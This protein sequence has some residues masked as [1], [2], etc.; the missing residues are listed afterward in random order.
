M[1]KRLEDWLKG[2]NRAIQGNG[3]DSPGGLRGDVL[4]LHAMLKE[5]LRRRRRRE[6]WIAAL[7][8][9]SFGSVLGAGVW[10][11]ARAYF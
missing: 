2:I 8:I 7:A 9:T 5:D 4:V 10:A 6:K 11:L 3:T 1:L